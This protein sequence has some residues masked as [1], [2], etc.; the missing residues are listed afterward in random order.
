MKPRLLTLNDHRFK[1]WIRKSRTRYSSRYKVVI[2]SP[3]G[4]Q[5]VFP[6]NEITNDDMSW[7]YDEELGGKITPAD[8][9]RTIEE[10]QLK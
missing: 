3:F 2:Q 1:W 5:Y 9:K 10:K 6:I 8:I 4:Y 7:D